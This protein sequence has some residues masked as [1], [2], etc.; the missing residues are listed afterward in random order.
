MEASWGKFLYI[1]GG[2]YYSLAAADFDFINFFII[3]Y[4]PSGLGAHRRLY[5]VTFTSS[6]RWVYI[7]PGQGRLLLRFNFL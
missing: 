5:D 4:M 3:V 6:D 2:F 7:D 1:T